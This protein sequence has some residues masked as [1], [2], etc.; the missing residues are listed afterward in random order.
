MKKILT[1]IALLANI[2]STYGQLALVKDIGNKSSMLDSKYISIFDNNT[3]YYVVNRNQIFKYENGNVIKIIESKSRITQLVKSGDFIYYVNSIN[4]FWRVH[5]RNFSKVQISDYDDYPFDEGVDEYDINDAPIENLLVNNDFVYFTYKDNIYKINSTSTLSKIVV[6]GNFMKSFKSLIKIGNQIYFPYGGPNDFFGS[7][8]DFNIGMIDSLDKETFVSDFNSDIAFFDKSIVIGNVLYIVGYSYIGSLRK[9]YLYKIDTKSNTTT[10]ILNNYPINLASHLGELVFTIVDTTPNLSHM[11]KTKTGS[12]GG[13]TFDTLT[14]MPGIANL[15]SAN[16]NLFFTSTSNAFGQE[17]YINKG[18]AGS[19]RLVKDIYPGA[20][21]SNILNLKAIDTTVVFTATSKD[22]NELWKSN[23]NAEGTV[24]IKDI[25]PGSG[26]SSPYG[27]RILNNEIYFVAN[28]GTTGFELWK[29]NRNAAGT[30]L[31]KDLQKSNPI[32]N[33]KELNGNLFFS[34]STLTSAES[35]WKSDG[36]AANTNLFS[37]SSLIENPSPYLLTKGK[38]YLYYFKND[39]KLYSTSIYLKRTNGNNGISEPVDSVN[40]KSS[41]ELYSK[42]IVK[43]AITLGDSI[44][45]I[46]SFGNSDSL[47]ASNGTLRGTQNVNFGIAMQWNSDFNLFNLITYKNEVYFMLC[48]YQLSLFYGLW[49]HTPGVNGITKVKDISELSKP[50]LVTKAGNLIYFIAQ[51]QLSGIE[52]WRSDGTALGTYM[53]KDINPGARSSN[54]TEIVNYKGI[55][56]FYANDGIHGNELWRSNGS[57]IGT[58][59]VKDIN[60]TGSSLVKKMTVS[61]DILFFSAGNGISG[62]ELWKSDGTAAGTQLVKDINPAGSSGPDNLTDVNG[63]LCFSALTNKGIELWKSDGTEEGTAMVA[64]MNPGAEYSS[65]SDLTNVDGT[66]YFV[67]YTKEI[68]RELWKYTPS[69]KALT[70]E[71]LIDNNSSI[72]LMPN[73]AIDHV[74]VVSKNEDEKIHSIEILNLQGSLIEKLE[75]KNNLHDYSVSH[76][77]QGIYLLKVYKENGSFETVKMVKQ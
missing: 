36:T 42:I 5:F 10:L 56:Y 1:C 28:D 60:P 47:V 37:S 19:T 9:N 75:N 68:G 3:L 72:Q 63:V 32:T 65:P 12:N 26:S 73:P 21:G 62:L 40:R 39:H 66:L 64:D 44:F 55:A 48:N 6:Y 24:Q 2:V 22:G 49:K 16:G 33:L 69:T 77:K 57:V 50:R 43:E 58:Y 8:N 52:L 15:T 18:V 20:T 23:G 11:F 41:T 30:V 14:S 38:N 71:G 25:H 4:E 45:F 74:V 46:W 17:L 27:L 51:N 54:I 35:L 67:A 31:V 70:R 29:S 76:L 13:I 53:V 59:L 7:P 61:N 34:T